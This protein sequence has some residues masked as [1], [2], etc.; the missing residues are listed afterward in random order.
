LGYL[1]ATAS[2]ALSDDEA[3]QPMTGDAPFRLTPGPREVVSSA[4]HGWQGA[5]AVDLGVSAGSESRHD[6]SQPALQAWWQ[7]LSLRPLQG[8]GGWR[9]VGAGARLWLPGERQ[10]FQVKQAS[11]TTLVFL[12]PERIEQILE[13]P[14]RSANLDRWRGLDFVSACVSRILAAMSDDLADG[15]PAGPIVGDSLTVALVAYLQAGPSR[16]SMAPSRPGP[17][18]RGLE[19][20]LEHVEANLAEPMRL[21]DLA[22]EAGCSPKQLSRAFRER[23]G[24]PPHR[25]VIERRVQ[26]A[27][28][29][30]EAGGA[31]L[32]QVAAEVGF[33][34]QSQMTKVFRKLKGTTPGRIR[35]GSAR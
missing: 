19:R 25:Y 10:Y 34:D 8:P 22:R 12:T 28:A 21:A 23:L 29:L 7:P 24:L 14:L 13:Q 4:T 9:T 18:P 1:S 20:A 3:L 11:R 16:A 27:I 2:P 5:L 32:A 30:I 15:C 31:H 17:S 33:S 6:H 35:R 26:R